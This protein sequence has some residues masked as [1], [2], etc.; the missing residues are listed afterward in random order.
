MTRTTIITFAAL[1]AAVP[2]L[3][4]ADITSGQVV[5]LTDAEITQSLAAEGFEV[6]EIEREDDELEV[7]VMRDG[8][9]F[10]LELDPATGVLL[11]MEA[12]DEDDQDD[13]DDNEDDAKEG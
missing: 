3:S 12:E 8:Q 10:E 9:E 7:E 13:E 1:I 5:G 11:A 4:F 6:L 2:A